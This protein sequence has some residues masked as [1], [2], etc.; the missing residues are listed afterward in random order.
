MKITIES[1][2]GTFD[3]T[4][5]ADERMLYSGLV[6][7]L[8]LPYECATGTCGTCRGR[9]ISGAVHVEW[10]EAPGYAKLRREKGD[11]LMCQSR[12]TADCTLRIPAK[13]APHAKPET[14][15]AH[16]TGRIANLRRLVHDVIDFD[17]VLSR[18]MTFDAGQFV[19]LEVPGIA[20]GRAYSM[21]NFDR[22]TSRLKLVIKQMPGGKFCDWLFGSDV[23][24]QE[25]KVFGPLG[26]ATYDPAEGRNILC[27]AG[28]SGIAG[29]LAIVA[30]AI[31]S[32][33]LRERT[34][35][36]FFGV[37]TLTDAFYMSEFAAFAATA[38]ANLE[39]T[40]ALSHASAET[41]TH[42]DFP[43][44]RLASGFV[45]DVAAQAMAGRTDNIVAFVAGP[46]IMV[47]IA[48]K[49]LT[50]EAKIP[51]TFIRYDKFA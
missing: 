16:R 14:L 7:G 39:V 38:G 29:M 9:V 22:G 26:R 2:S 23:S 35:H 1:N 19:V 42:P 8:S 18:P 49:H 12:P 6:Q 15:P 44:I 10:Q 3:F 17:L 5:E 34:A 32:G 11:V 48:L 46:P 30:H 43:T 41:P 27:I 51:R 13:I 36:V 20:G 24:G 47:D 28:G 31:G 45:T 33:A 50:Y 21:V 37:R 4:C 40:L 25:L